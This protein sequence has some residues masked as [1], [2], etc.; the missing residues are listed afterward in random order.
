[1]CKVL[2]SEVGDFFSAWHGCCVHAVTYLLSHGRSETKSYFTLNS[3]PDPQHF[4][5]TDIGV[6]GG[7]N[8]VPS[9]QAE[10]LIYIGSS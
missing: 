3:C 10:Q 8:H 1:L 6:A 4:P 7:K 5:D 9:L 2:S